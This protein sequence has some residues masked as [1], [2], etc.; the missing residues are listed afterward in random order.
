[1]NW[2]S[3]L[4]QSG[5]RERVNQQFLEWL[6]LFVGIYLR[7]KSYKSVYVPKNKKPLICRYTRV[8][9]RDYI[10]RVQNTLFM[11]HILGSHR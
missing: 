7:I 8:Y 1:M 4:H 10:E 5:L 2:G 11:F 6:R 9:V 3:N